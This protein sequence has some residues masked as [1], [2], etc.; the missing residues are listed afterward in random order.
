M[1]QEVK[2]Y[3]QLNHPNLVKLLDFSADGVLKEKKGNDTKLIDIAYIVLELVEGVEI[4][5]Y[6][7]YYN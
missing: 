6:L 5:Y 7:H 2:I 4:W 3:K 1:N